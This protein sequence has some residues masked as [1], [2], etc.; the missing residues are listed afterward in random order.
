MPTTPRSTTPKAATTP[1]A[2]PK[3]KT[4][5]KAKKGKGGRYKASTQNFNDEDKEFLM[6]LLEEI[7]PVGPEMWDQVVSHYNDKYVEP[8]QRT[9][10]DKDG[11][12]THYYK[13]YKTAKPMGNPTC[14]EYIQHTKKLKYKIEDKVTMTGIDDEDLELAA[15]DIEVDEEPE[16]K[17]N[18]IDNI[19]DNTKSNTIED[20]AESNTTENDNNDNIQADSND[21]EYNGTDHTVTIAIKSDI[22]SSTMT[23]APP[24]AASQARKLCQKP[25]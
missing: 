7:C 9:T 20:N 24:S 16:P 10:H 19:E 15:S 22:T 13:M 6:I 5:P 12:H 25:G 3:A 23:W 4:T 1:K 8:N 21:D 2:I 17:T 18:N 11:L 14:P